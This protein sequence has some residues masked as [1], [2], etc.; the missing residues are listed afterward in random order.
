MGVWFVA[1]D[2]GTRETDR[3]GLTGQQA[4]RGT[5]DA[6]P[7][8]GRLAKQLEAKN[9]SKDPEPQQP[10]RVVVS[11]RCSPSSGLRLADDRGT[12]VGLRTKRCEFFSPS[13]RREA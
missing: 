13:L 9:A 5:N 7:N 4:R 6:N 2:G 10:T 1:G 12:L 8:Q 3:L 11:A